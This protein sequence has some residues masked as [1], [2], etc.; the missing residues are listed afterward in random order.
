[1]KRFAPAKINLS[2]EILGKRTDGF[3]DLRSLF[4]PISLLD[5]L[6]FESAEAFSFTC[7][8]SGVP[9]DE[10]NL[11]VRAA[12][13]FGNGE[14]PKLAIHLE[15][16]IPHSAGL[17]GGSSDAAT[18]L[19]AL[20]ELSGNMRSL[21][22]LEDLAA[23]LGSDVPFFLHRSAAWCE[24]RGEVVRPV[25]TPDNFFILLFKPPFGVPTPWAYQKLAES[26]PLP[27]VPMDAQSTAAGTLV[28]DLERP[29][30][31]KYLLLAL[32]KQFLLEQPET[33]GALMSGSGSTMFAL[34]QDRAGA[35]LLR[36]RLLEE[37]GPNN[38]TAITTPYVL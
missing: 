14:L 5:E 4:L 29:V 7:S 28:N 30:F 32:V 6:T 9:V 34:T 20:N 25:P 3:H 37:F 35:E 36:A 22:K 26:L 27:G 18:T 16:N 31:A 17:G 21:P 10:T 23:A 13:V 24:G 2:L 38:W 11:V 12:K 19:L 1:M 8:D 15:K 33:L